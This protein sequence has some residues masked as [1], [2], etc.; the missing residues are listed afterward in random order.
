MIQ[1]V[2]VRLLKA[3]RADSLAERIQL[4][5]LVAAL[6]ALR[7]TATPNCCNYKGPPPMEGGPGLVLPAMA[8]ADD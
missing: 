4:V 2:L 1:A 6:N 3:V 7:L 8:R 5:V